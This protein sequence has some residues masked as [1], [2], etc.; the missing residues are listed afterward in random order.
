M[1]TKIVLLILLIIIVLN[2]SE[3]SSP[4]TA[5]TFDKMDLLS[6]LASDGNIQYDF[7]ARS[8]AVT[9][10]GTKYTFRLNSD[11]RVDLIKDNIFY[12]TFKETESRA[13]QSPIDDKNA[14]KGI[15][16]RRSVFDKYF[17]N[18]SPAYDRVTYIE[19]MYGNLLN[20]SVPKAEINLI[21]KLQC[22]INNHK[23]RI[24]PHHNK[25]DI[26]TTMDKITALYPILRQLRYNLGVSKE[27]I[28][29][30]IFR[31]MM[32]YSLED[33]WFGETTGI[34]QI[35]VRAAR[36]NEIVINKYDRFQDISDSNLK[37]L[38][39]DDKESIYFAS[40]ALIK[41][42]KTA[43]IPIATSNRSAIAKI[44]EYYNGF[45]GYG[46]NMGLISLKVTFGP[47]KHKV[48]YGNQT[49]KYYEAFKSYYDIVDN[50]TINQ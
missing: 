20:N 27:M 46:L 16:I 42:A 26:H 10:N 21:K 19:H 2:S 15:L 23:I 35:G 49:Y 45:E 12:G 14:I 25:Y 43:G 1:Q 8:A 34:A 36:K 9:K 4:G 3:T 41:S 18:T 13:P 50:N 37:T 28:S 7:G 11:N 38:I 40:A 30:V 39:E 32:C 48:T 17:I 22:D 29:S 6:K 31:E 44:F 33:D 47:I 24:I 5:N